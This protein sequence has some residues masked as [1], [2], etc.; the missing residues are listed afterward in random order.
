[1]YGIAVHLILRSPRLTSEQTE[2]WELDDPD[3]QPLET[4]YRVKYEIN[5][6]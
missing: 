2:D 6:A 4:F 5:G 3:G 1:M